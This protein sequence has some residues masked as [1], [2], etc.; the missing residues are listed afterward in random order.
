MTARLAALLCLI[1]LAA[2]PGNARGEESTDTALAD[3]VL[4]DKSDR[5]LHLLR[6]GEV[7]KSYPIGLGFA[8]EGHKRREGDGRT[9]EGDYVLDWRNPNSSFYLSI[10][11]SFPDAD[12][13]A[14]A[15]QRGVSAGGAI[16]IHGR[17]RLEGRKRDWTLGCIAVTDAAMDEIWQAVPDGTP[18][19]IRP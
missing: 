19:T 13:T 7:W 17:H 10:H 18:I 3:K 14:A 8:P 16:F 12:D 9:P 11:I 4:V 15:R 1:A 5:Q 2:T 6:D